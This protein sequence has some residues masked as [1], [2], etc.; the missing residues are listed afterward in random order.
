MVLTEEQFLYIEKMVDLFNENTHGIHG[1]DYGDAIYSYFKSTPE[2]FALLND[3]DEGKPNDPY[4][5]N[6]KNEHSV[7]V[8][9]RLVVDELN[10][11][12]DE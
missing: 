9:I 6:E 10:K 4:W 11:M 2:S 3:W 1:V 7:I 8:F 12:N 5:D